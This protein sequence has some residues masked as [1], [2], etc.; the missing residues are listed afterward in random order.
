[1]VEINLDTVLSLVGV[2]KTELKA[3]NYDY[4]N[5]LSLVVSFRHEDGFHARKLS[6]MSI[7]SF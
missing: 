2:I 5:S 7:L 1:M 6:M 3:P 4:G